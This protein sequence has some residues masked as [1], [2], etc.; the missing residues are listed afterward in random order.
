MHLLLFSNSTNPA[1]KYLEYTLSYIDTFL[2]KAGRK[3]LFI[4]YAG[5]SSG[6]DAYSDMVQKSLEKIS[7]EIN[8]IHKIDDKKKAIKTAEI[9]IIGGGNTFYLLKCLQDEGLLDVIRKAVIHDTL[10]IGWSAGSNLACPT[11]RTTNDMPIV[12]PL[13]L[14]ALNLIPFQINPHYTDFH[15]PGHA[16]ETREMRI[17]EFLLVNRQLYVIGLREGTLLHIKDKEISLLGS[18]SCKIFKY[19]Q[20]PFEVDIGENLDFLMQ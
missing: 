16:G 13:N 12:Q 14:N 4:P 11:I 15:P 19:G 7:L 17:K 8:S 20:D 6:F 2:V 5:I 3:A 9:V 10:Y 1:E 18:K